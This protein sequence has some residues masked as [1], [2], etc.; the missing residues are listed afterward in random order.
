MNF[1]QLKFKKTVFIFNK[2]SK[3]LKIKFV[4]VT[5]FSIFAA[6]SELASIAI[7]IPLVSVLSDSAK[8]AEILNIF[9]II[10][11]FLN[12]TFD[13][14][15]IIILSISF[16]AGALLFASII[17][18]FY[19]KLSSKL[20][21]QIG[22]FLADQYYTNNLNLEL[23]QA[24]AIDHSK[25]ISLLTSET[26]SVC[27]GY[28]LPLLRAIGCFSQIILLSIACLLY[29]TKP[30]IFAISGIL[31]SYFVISYFNYKIISK[32]GI[33]INNSQIELVEH[34]RNAMGSR[35]DLIL[36]NISKRFSEK[37]NSTMVRLRNMQAENSFLATYPRYVLESVFI[38]SIC[39]YLI[40]NISR[41][42][43]LKS[44]DISAILFIT[45]SSQKIL[46][47]AQQ[48]YGSIAEIK[49]TNDSLNSLINPNSSSIIKRKNIPK[50]NEFDNLIKFDS[51]KLI[52][53]KG[54]YTYPNSKTP[55][56]LDLDFSLIPG[57]K[58]LIKGKSGSGK[59]TLM[60]LLMGLITTD[61][62]K[63]DFNN[64]IERVAFRANCMHV[65]QSTFLLSGSIFSN[66]TLAN[67]LNTNENK[68]DALSKAFYYSQLA[69]LD[70]I[71][72]T[73]NDLFKQVGEN[74]SF[75]SGG[76]KQR[77]SIARALY[78]ESNYLFLDEA[79]SA[80][81]KS[82]EEKLLKKIFENKKNCTIVCISHDK[83][84]DKFADR[85]IKVNQN[86]IL[87]VE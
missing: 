16:F 83:G 14:K 55:T 22:T 2:L 21:Y 29:S 58:L 27:N 82:T 11:I 13:E 67:F 64:F 78:R 18:I 53:L 65:P 57:E 52:H 6:L 79:T 3:E 17:R 60:D 86:R 61:I 41:N 34:I 70:D 43:V 85:F 10:G 20:A 31:I 63:N 69:C 44:E 47:S 73:K 48:F 80:I 38:I 35:R 23:E 25:I 28:F 62:Y 26:Y 77:I 72:K 7:I 32:N 49:S 19:A 5:L 4:A 9:P 50:Q 71:I 68:N 81:D 84:F 8:F 36:M 66:I 40:I 12:S 39:L 30:G 42:G 51:S 54:N 46:P 59:S 56:L 1:F 15:F 33:R 37:A 24:E 87:T 74:G 45:I 75:L 76:Q